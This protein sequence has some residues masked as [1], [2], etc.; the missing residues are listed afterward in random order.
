MRIAVIGF[1]VSG[2]I[3]SIAY[4]RA[5]PKDEIIILE[6]LDSPLKK[7]LATGNGKCNIGN[8]SSLKGIYNDEFISGILE[9]YDYKTQ[10]KF[11]DSLNIKTKLV[12]NLAYP[13][14]ESAVTV[15]NA[16]LKAIEA[17]KI[18]VIYNANIEDYSI[19]DKD[20]DIYLS[21][22]S[23]KVDRLVIA[24]G[25]KSTPKLGSDG[26]IF[27]V[28]NDHHYRINKLEPGLCPIVTKE[29]FKELDGTRVKGEVTVRK[30]NKI[31][32]KE[33]GEILFKKH[34]LSGIVIF[35]AS[36]I[37]AHD[38]SAKYEISLDFLPEISKDDLGIFLSFNKADVLLDAYLHPLISERI[39]KENLNG[40]KL[41]DRIK[42][43]KCH[44]D[45][46]SGFEF[47]QVTIGGV[48]L[49]DVNNKLES[50]IEKHVYF[51]GEVLDVDAPCGGY[52]LM[53][54]IASGLY[55]SDYL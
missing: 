55:L 21:D 14:S 44:F 11:L 22:R 46:L 52:N 9:K 36:R 42:S 5:H 45:S 32:F 47:S 10:E 38:L 29:S 16:L 24:S 35:N 20:I 1:G 31:V 33:K 4:K 40:I 19:N 48:S 15:R 50:N 49:K 13:I 43:F 2:A 3:F 26:S 27:S 7:V 25:G 18:E 23:L 28:L 54:A 30:N 12:G 8:N 34:G 39:K 53:W 6:H 17:A 41:L 37:I 51:I